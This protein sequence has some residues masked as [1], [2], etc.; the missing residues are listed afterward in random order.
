[1]DANTRIPLT[2]LPEALYEAGYE[3]M[4]YRPL[5]TAAVDRRIPAQRGRNGRWTFSAEDLGNIAEALGLSDA[6]AA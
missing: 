3:T 1:M 6:H 5:Y 2:L 4:P